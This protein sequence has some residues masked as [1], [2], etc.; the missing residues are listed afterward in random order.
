MMLFERKKSICGNGW[1]RHLYVEVQLI[2]E[3]SEPRLHLAAEVPF[4]PGGRWMRRA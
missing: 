2:D 1:I 4:L 3:N